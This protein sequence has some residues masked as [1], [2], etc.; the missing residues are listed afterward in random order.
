[1]IDDSAPPVPSRHAVAVA[2]RR[3]CRCPLR[4]CA[5][6]PPG[7][8]LARCLRRGAV[9]VVYRVWSP[10]QVRTEFGRWS[11]ATHRGL[12]SRKYWGEWAKRRVDA[13]TVVGRGGFQT[14]PNQTK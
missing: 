9:G 1:M 2:G 11:S 6:P 7:P 10:V 12:S 14:K 13:V 8:L 3:P 5:A 4:G